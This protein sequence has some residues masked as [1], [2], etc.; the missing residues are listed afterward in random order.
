MLSTNEVTI[1]QFVK[2]KAGRDKDRVFII[3]SKLDDEYV[4]VTDGDLRRMENPKKK[5]IK[6]LS[7]YNLVSELV[8]E[9]HLNTKKI[10]NSIIR[11][12]IEK[13]G[14]NKTQI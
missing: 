12:E 3:I 14:L 8:K 10:T 2:S 9:N 4:L 5:K 1:G 7:K 13:Y 6:H 11:K